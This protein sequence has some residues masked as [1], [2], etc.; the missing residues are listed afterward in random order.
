MFQA[1]LGICLPYAAA[2]PATLTQYCLL[3]PPAS[4]LHYPLLCC[5][6]RGNLLCESPPLP[7]T[8]THILANLQMALGDLVPPSQDGSDMAADIAELQAALQASQLELQ[9]ARTAVEE[10]TQAEHQ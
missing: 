3:L 2:D 10:A 6:S 9:G 5:A 8:P 4:Y 7:T 1:V